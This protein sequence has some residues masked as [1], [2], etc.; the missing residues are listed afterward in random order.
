M[1]ISVSEEYT[2]P[3]FRNEEALVSNYGF[4]R[5]T[6]RKN[7]VD[8]STVV[9]TSNLNYSGCV[10]YHSTV[11]ILHHEMSGG[12]YVSSNLIIIY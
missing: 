8:V 6:T 7:N 10:L 11:N 9:I 5:V 1:E 12:R 3:F 2:V 4:T